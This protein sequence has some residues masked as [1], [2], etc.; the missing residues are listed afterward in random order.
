[1]SNPNKAQKMETSSRMSVINKTRKIQ[2]IAALK[3]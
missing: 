3:R 1:M 2:T